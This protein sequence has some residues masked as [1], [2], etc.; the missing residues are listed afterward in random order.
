[1][2]K[3]SIT[4]ERIVSQ[5]L[6]RIHIESRPKNLGKQLDFVNNLK[7]NSCVLTI[8][9]IFHDCEIDYHKY[10]MDNPEFEILPNFFIDFRFEFLLNI[11][12]NHLFL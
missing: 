8:P 3:I 2:R 6:A 4:I 11:L 10:N 9:I 12:K 1:M 5:G 7:K